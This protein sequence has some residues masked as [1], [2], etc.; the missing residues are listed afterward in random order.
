MAPHDGIE[1]IDQS[2][3]RI[4]ELDRVL[5]TVITLAA[6]LPAPQAGPLHGVPVLVKD[7]I[8]TADL[9]TTAGSRALPGC[10]PADAPVVRRLRAAGAVVVGKANLSEW[11]NFRS[12]ESVDGWSATGGQTLNPLAHGHSPS[13]SSS[14]SA[15]AVAAGLVPLALGTET[16]GS[17]VSPAAVCGVVGVKPTLGLVDTTGVV[18]ITSEQ[19]CV[20]PIT[21]TVADAARA[22]EVLSGQSM[23]LDLDILPGKRIGVWRLSGVDAGL[24]AAVENAVRLLSDAGATVVELG[25][26]YQDEIL[27]NAFA[28]MLTEFADQLPRYLAT[29][30]DAPDTLADLIAFNR[31]DPVELSVFGQD[32]FEKALDAPP[33]DDPEYLRRRRTAT[34]LARRSIDEPM[35]AAKLDAILA[36]T[37]NPA[38]PLGTHPAPELAIESAAPAAVAGYP[39]VTVPAG[40]SGALPVGVTFF[41]RPRT[42]ATLLSIAGAFEQARGVIGV[43][44]SCG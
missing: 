33:P 39:A 12:S 23:S 29:R 14:G 19:D 40:R 4:A 35:T 28:A 30:P 18:P 3:E 43:W 24:D 6:E 42:D 22:L 16:I 26:N 7:N 27:D 37:E 1:R 44:N 10:A 41:G 36:P 2:L 20:G 21:R 17:I 11:A 38:D 25:L 9:P 13:G 8:D 32:L 5:H 34:G 15:A 31:A